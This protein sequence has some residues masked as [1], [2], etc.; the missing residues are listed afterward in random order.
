M[1][2]APEILMDLVAISSISSEPNRPVIEYALRY[3][4]P[5]LWTTTLH[6]Y[7]D[8]NGIEKTNLIA[9]TGSPAELALVCHTDTVPYDAAWT[10]AVQP[11]AENGRIIGRGSCD[12][13]GFLACVLSA[14][15]QLDLPQLFKPLA[16][17]LTSDEEIGCIGAKFLA[18]QNAFRTHYMIIG[19]PTR[20]R[21]A[22][23]GKGYGLGEII[24][25]GQEA[26]SAFPHRGRSAIR[27]AARIIE[28]LDAVAAEL[29]AHPNP[30]FDPPFT[31][32]NIGLIQG[33]TAK[34]IIPGECRMTIEWRPVP[35][36]PADTA[37][38]LI[39]HEFEQ[40]P[41]EFHLKRL[42]PPFEPS[43]SHRLVSLIPRPVTTLSFGTEAAH[44]RQLAGEIIVLGPG[45]MTVAH[46]TGE[47]VPISE[48]DECVDLF[49]TIIESICG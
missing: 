36:Q 9:A 3:L 8:P 15:G 22:R 31:T 14:L 33:G 46:K 24:V 1:K 38:R 43:T 42:D 45:D 27:D 26:H 37:V 39:E 21:P 16:L 29:A 35:G 32:L 41:A 11:T 28:R 2:T 47:F 48:L 19:E 5:R 6:T 20:L 7:R 40:F 25:H 44:L 30:D 34:N 18:S 10:G 12:V 49:K 23:A 4:D 13:K 17:I